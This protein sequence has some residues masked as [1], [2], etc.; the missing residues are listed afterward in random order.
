MGAFYA[1]RASEGNEIL[2]VKSFKSVDTMRGHTSQDNFLIAFVHL[3]DYACSSHIYGAPCR[4]A[5]RI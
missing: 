5:P 4:D 1:P 3:F 2:Q